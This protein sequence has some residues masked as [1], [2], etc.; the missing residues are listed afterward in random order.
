[1]P[2]FPYPP[3]RTKFEAAPGVISDQWARWLNLVQKQLS[4]AI[5]AVTGAKAGNAALTSLIT[6]LAQKGIITDSST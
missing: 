3:I 5:P 2:A 6:I 1:M 4:T